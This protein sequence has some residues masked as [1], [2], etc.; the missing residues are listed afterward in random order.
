MKPSPPFVQPYL[1]FGGHCAEALDY[2]AQHLGATIGMKMTFEQ[3]PQAHPEVKLPLGWEKKI[4][5]A[6]F[7]IG[8]SVLMGSDGMAAADEAH[9][10]KHCMSLTLGSVAEA[11]R[12]FAALADGGE[13]M[14][15]LG[16]TFYAQSFGMVTDRFGIGWMITT[17]L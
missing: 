13:V 12:A 6:E 14:M 17:P 16:P 8:S 4:M 7:T 9:P 15:P 10:G 5:H 11:E 2:Y 1:F 3:S